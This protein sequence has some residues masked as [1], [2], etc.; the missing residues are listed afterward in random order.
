METLKV[1]QIKVELAWEAWQASREAIEIKL[2]DKVMVDD[3]FDKGHNCAID[4]CADAIR[5]AGIKVKE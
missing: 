3:E 1:M 2:D 5:A 4:Y